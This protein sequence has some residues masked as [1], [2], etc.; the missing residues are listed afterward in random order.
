VI[1]RLVE[2]T[3][4]RVGNEEYAWQNGSFGLTTLKN[5]HVEVNGSSIRFRFRGKSGAFHA[6][7]VNDRRLASLVRRLRDLPGQE[8]FQYLGE[9]GEPQRVDSTDVNAYLR[10]I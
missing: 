3:F 10:E 6:I 5:R 7:Q 1:G 8:L 2:T 4:V 9:D